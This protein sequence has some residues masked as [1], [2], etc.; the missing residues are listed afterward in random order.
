MA[1][2]CPWV[3][4]NASDIHPAEV[5]SDGAVRKSRPVALFMESDV[6]LFVHDAASLALDVPVR[7]EMRS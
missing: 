4:E 7:P 5:Y 2:C 6:G 1:R 3:L